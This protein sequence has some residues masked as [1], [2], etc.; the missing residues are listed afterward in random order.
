MKVDQLQTDK[1]LNLQKV[2]QNNKVEGKDSFKKVFN[3]ALHKVNNLQKQQDVMA[4]KLATGEVDNIH[5]V[6]VTATKAKLALDLTLEIRNKA[7]ESY[8]EIMRMQV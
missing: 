5:Q 3:N 1:L 4:K 2:N 8:K 6:M 7:V